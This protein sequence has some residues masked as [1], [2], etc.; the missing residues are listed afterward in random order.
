M[1]LSIRRDGV[2][3]SVKNKY[4]ESILK[5]AIQHL[6]PMQLFSDL[7]TEMEKYPLTLSVNAQEYIPGRTGTVAAKLQIR[8][9]T[10][11]QKLL[12]INEQYLLPLGTKCGES[13]G[14]I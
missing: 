2:T 12:P 10:E 13:V 4:G 8:E 1:K 5:S 9:V 6:F 7:V 14:N 3:R 11:Y